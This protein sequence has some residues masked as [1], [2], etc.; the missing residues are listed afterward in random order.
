[1]PS[2]S[3]SNATTNSAQVVIGQ[4]TLKHIVHGNGRRNGLKIEVFAFSLL[5]VV[6][7]IERS[8]PR[9]IAK[10]REFFLNVGGRAEMGS[11]LHKF[12]H[13]AAA[14]CLKSKRG[15]RTWM[16]RHFSI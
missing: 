3:P 15:F 8:L 14:V 4:L 1:L 5:F 11:F 12:L 2:L 9:Q 10:I 16:T 6:D 13:T 7:Q